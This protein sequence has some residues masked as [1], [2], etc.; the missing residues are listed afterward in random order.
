MSSAATWSAASS[1]TASRMRAALHALLDSETLT[2]E[3]DIAH[4]VLVARGNK[5]M[6][7]GI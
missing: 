3:M 4:A 2:R 5:R 7:P 1:P 6:G